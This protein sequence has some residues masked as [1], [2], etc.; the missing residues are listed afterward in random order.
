MN[1]WKFSELEYTRP[2]FEAAKTQMTAWTEQVKNAASAQEIFSI[3]SELDEEVKHLTTQFTLVYVRHTL[4]TTDEFY[5]KEQEYLNEQLPEISPYQV[6]HLFFIKFIGCIQCVAQRLQ[7]R[8]S[9]VSTMG[10]P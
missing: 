2:D 9:S 4:D 10:V 8:H 5:E 3:I 7:P 6:F 1:D